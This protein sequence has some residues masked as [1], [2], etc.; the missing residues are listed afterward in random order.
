MKKTN[1]DMPT[2]KSGGRKLR[3]DLI[4]ISAI[5]FSRDDILLRF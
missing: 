2:A 4:L 1:N 5:L 3:N